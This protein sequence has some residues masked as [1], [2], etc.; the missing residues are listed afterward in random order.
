MKY[1]KYHLEIREISA[2]KRVMVA[3]KGLGQRDLKG[4]TKDFTYF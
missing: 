3:I 4:D 2:S 1:I